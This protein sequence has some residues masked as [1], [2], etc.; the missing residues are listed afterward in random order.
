MET[1]VLHVSEAEAERD[2]AA[3]LQHVRT[4]AEVVI[5]RH[6]QPVA[7]IRAPGPVRRTISE[8]IALAEAHEKETG[9]VPVFDADFATDVEEIIRSRKPW[10]PELGKGMFFAN[11]SIGE[12]AAAQDV[13]PLQSAAELGTSIAEETENIDLMLETIY[14]SRK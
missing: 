14:S 5:E 9:Q 13:K 3:I 1:R 11:P 7:V 4:G 2:L 10:N 12:L 6:A 8:C